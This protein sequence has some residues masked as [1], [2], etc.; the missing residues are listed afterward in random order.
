MARDFRP[1]NARASHKGAAARASSH[2][3]PSSAAESMGNGKK[4]ALSAKNEVD[5]EEEEDLQS[6]DASEPSDIDSDDDEALLREIKA[7]GGDES[8]LQLIRGG[9]EAN[10]LQDARDDDV[11]ET[12]FP[13]PLLGQSRSSCPFVNHLALLPVGSHLFYGRTRLQGRWPEEASP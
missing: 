8:D 3:G 13:M 7:M 5:N 1:K 12:L 4:I 6:I 9:Q 11:S 2:A 10:A